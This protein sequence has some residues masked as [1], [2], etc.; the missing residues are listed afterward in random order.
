MINDKSNILPYSKRVFSDALEGVVLKTFCGQAP[1]SPFPSRYTLTAASGLSLSPNDMAY[2]HP[3][4]KTLGLCY[5]CSTWNKDI[6]VSIQRGFSSLVHMILHLVFIT[7]AMVFFNFRYQ[8]MEK[9]FAGHNRLLQG[10]N[11]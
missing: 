5:L 9:F 6:L 4:P 3:I 7:I 8:I 1:R 11:L 2:H 10:R